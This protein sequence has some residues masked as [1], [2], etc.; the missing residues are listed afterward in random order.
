MGVLIAYPSNLTISKS[1]FYC[2]GKHIIITNENSKK[3]ASKSNLAILVIFENPSI[4]L[5]FGININE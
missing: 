3:A 1:E 5:K 2:V 4:N